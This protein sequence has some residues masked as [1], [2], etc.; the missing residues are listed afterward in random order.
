MK[1]WLYS[2][3]SALA[4]RGKSVLTLTESAV[5]MQLTGRARLSESEVDC[6]ILFPSL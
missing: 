4:M 1:Y 5:E 2:S 3:V 6:F